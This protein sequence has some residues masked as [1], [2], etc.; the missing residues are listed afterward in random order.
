M[1][2]GGFALVAEDE[3]CNITGLSNFGYI[4]LQRHRRAQ[5]DTKII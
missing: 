1:H 2:V 4:V 5:H 3:R